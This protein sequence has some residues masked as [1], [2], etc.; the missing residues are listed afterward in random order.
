[1]DHRRIHLQLT[2]AAKAGISERSGRRIDRDPTLPSQRKKPRVY[3]TRANPFEGIWEAE[4][5]PLVQSM[6]SLQAIT[7][8][9]ELQ[10]RH[11]GRFPDSQLRTLQRH[12][13]RWSAL[14]GPDR[15]VIFRQEHPP[16][17]QGLSDF[18][19]AGELC[20]TMAGLAFPHRLYHFA[21]AHSQWEYARVVEGG[22]SFS[23]LA[24]GLQNAL[25]LIGG[26]PREH[27]TDSLS[28]AFKNLSEQED[29]TRAYRELCT[30]YGMAA[31]R[32][33]RGV[34]HENGSIESPHRH[35]KTALDQALTLRGSRD[36]DTRAAYQAFADDLVGKRNAARERAFAAD[37]AALLP[38]PQ[39]RTTDFSEATVIVTSSSMFCLRKVFYTV[40]SRLIGHRLK[41]HLYDDRLDCF[42]GSTQ[43]LALPRG[44]VPS[45]A[46]RGHVADYRHVLPS[47]RRKPQ[48]LRNLVW[49]D[50]LFPRP[51]FRRA[52]DMLAERGP[53]E[54][55][56]RTMVAL[57]DIAYCS[58]REAEL[59][60]HI[61]IALDA[62]NLPDPD[63]LR[64]VFIRDAASIHGAAGLPTVA[65]TMPTALV[66]D[67]LLPGLR[68][69]VL[70]C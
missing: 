68:V 41:V 7:I 61:E 57:L 26:A 43:V 70:P 17:A 56:C 16:G 47:L 22:E 63:A 27:R 10:R 34:S 24:E 13:R 21:L 32:N 62:G 15:D 8:L 64:A 50:V 4:I 31:T 46:Q 59:A 51:A 38:L 60:E 66:Y 36:F 54:R 65:V 14:A 9:R 49:R 37:R 12:I 11:P 52:W 29:F 33:N 6:P 53:I 1:M 48:A 67:V 20:V 5:V 3:R 58:G 42:L 44:R 39:R 55:A 19:D 35:L 30:H 25:W 28:A 40:P 2:A 69:E 18:T 45:G 23:A